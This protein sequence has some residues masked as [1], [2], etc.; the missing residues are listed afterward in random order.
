MKFASAFDAVFG[1][2]G[3]EMLKTRHGHRGL[4][5]SRIGGCA[6]F[7]PNAWIG[8]SSILAQ[9]ATQARWSEAILQ[10]IDP[11][12]NVRMGGGKTAV[13]S[14]SHR[15]YI[16]SASGVSPS[17]YVDELKSQPSACVQVE[18]VGDVAAVPLGQEQSGGL[19]H[20]EVS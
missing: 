14:A 9:V 11:L 8:R 16:S 20:G 19:E 5:P 1:W 13:P 15:T 17:D 18:P 3:I 7:G 10:G 12:G 4:T 6:P 2:A